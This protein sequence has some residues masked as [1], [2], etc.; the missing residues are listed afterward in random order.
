M[1]GACRRAGRRGERAGAHV[2]QRRRESGQIIV[3]FA[4]GMALFMFS[5]FVAVV[6]L[7]Y[8]FTWSAR[9]QAA[10][11]A[12][13]QT[14]A[15]SVNPAY[16]YT[17]QLP[18]VCAGICVSNYPTVDY[19]VACVHNGNVSADISPATAQ[20]T[21][22]GT[23]GT[24]CTVGPN[25]DA[26]CEVSATV[27][28]KVQFPLT[29]LGFGAEVRGSFVAAPVIGANAPAGGQAPCPYVPPPS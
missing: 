1:T 6:D 7:D 23:E 13:A 25:P 3:M 24:A 12:A 18:M 9:V 20:Y 26:A 27:V 4:L 14:G 21:V 28:K 5:L 29:V 15:N 8:L 16:L 10:A 19:H 17:G 22:P 2:R 11:Q